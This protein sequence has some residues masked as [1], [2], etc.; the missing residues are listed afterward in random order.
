MAAT[1]VQSSDDGLNSPS[2]ERGVVASASPWS[3]IVRGVSEGV[4]PAVGSAPA[5]PSWSSVPPEH[6]GNDSPP[7]WSLSKPVHDDDLGAY[8]QADNA[9][10]KPVWNRPSP[11]GGV[12]D[13]FSPVMGAAWPALSESTKPTHKSSSSES[14]KTLSDGSLSPALLVSAW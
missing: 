9:S 8:S 2:S 14:L 3:Q 12:V 13:S 6:V 5:S 7:D 4:S 10:K 1:N 11:N